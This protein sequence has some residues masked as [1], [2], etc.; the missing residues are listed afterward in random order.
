MARGDPILCQDPGD[1]LQFVNKTRSEALVSLFDDSLE[2][3]T[4]KWIHPG[5]ETRGISAQS[6]DTF[7]V[8]N[9]DGRLLYEYSMPIDSKM[10]ITE[11]YARR[12][13]NIE[14]ELDGMILYCHRLTA[15]GHY[16]K[17][18]WQRL[19]CLAEALD[20]TRRRHAAYEAAGPR[21]T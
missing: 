15:S 8:T 3:K 12:L 11:Y 18:L 19:C 6:G 7:F 2:L 10:S 4:V 9:G 20:P 5:H 21:F 17:R 1:V 16:Q 13:L 14:C